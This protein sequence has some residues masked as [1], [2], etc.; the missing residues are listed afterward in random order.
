MTPEEPPKD[1]LQ[2]LALAEQLLA[3]A[4][5]ELARQR[6]A[7]GGGFWE[8]LLRGGFVD[9]TALREAAQTH[10]L[11]LAPEY[12]CIRIHGDSRVRDRALTAFGKIAHEATSDQGDHALILIV[13]I[14]RPADMTTLRRS[15]T[16]L[17]RACGREQL[18]IEGGIGTIEPPS[19]LHRSVRNAMVA[20]VIG[21][22]MH[23]SGRIASFSEL[24]AYPLLYDGVDLPTLRSFAER[25]LSPIRTYDEKH[26]TELE[27]TLRVYID[28][29]QN[30]KTTAES[31][32]VHRHT[33]FYRLRQINEISDMSFENPQ[34]QLA[35]RLA[36]AMETLHHD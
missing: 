21:Q 33:V 24:G 35:L 20:L 18:E 31:L 27:R 32:F 15:A 9:A 36:L 22:R 26:Q 25:V 1:V 23:G 29:G 17:A 4:R 11:E 30:V 16:T 13:P 28:S 2:A 5:K 34:D 8:T 19:S 12:L 10:H 3:H 7:L 14:E 6:S